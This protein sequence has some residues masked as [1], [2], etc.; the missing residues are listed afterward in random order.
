VHKGVLIMTAIL[1]R[2]YVEII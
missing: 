2:K 1:Q